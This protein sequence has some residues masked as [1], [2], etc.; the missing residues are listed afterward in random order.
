MMPLHRTH[1]IVMQNH[2]N[3]PQQVSSQC[4]FRLQHPKTPV[5][6]QQSH[7][8]HSRTAT[9]M[10]LSQPHA[11][12]S[13]QPSQC[14][15]HNK[16][17]CPNATIAM[18]PSQQSHSRAS[19]TTLQWEK[20]NCPNIA[21]SPKPSH[22]SHTNETIPIQPYQWTHSSTAISTLQRK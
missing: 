5:P 12:I 20:Y 11:A 1:N 17:S 2:Y 13:A 8:N 15:D 21:I 14:L 9:L 3:I 7:C 6:L 22:C 18:H 4:T 16:S 19:I 10:L